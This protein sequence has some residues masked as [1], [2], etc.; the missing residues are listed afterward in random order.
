MDLNILWFILIAVL[1][2]G[3]F[4]LE[5]FDYGVGILLPFLGKTDNERRV[6][7]NSIGPVWDGNE[8]WLI[9]SGGAIF[10][11]FPN[12]YATLFSGFY[13]ALF[14]M[15]AALIVRGVAFEFRSSD[16][17][18]AWR[19]LWDG[20]L[21]A[22][23]LV[24]AL[25]WGVA[26]TNLLQGVPIDGNMQ[27][28]GGFFDLLS[29]YTL[30]GGLVFVFL[31]VFHG[32]LYLGLKTEGEMATRAERAARFA[33]GLGLVFLLVLALLTY[34][35]TDLFNKAGAAIVL[36][37]AAVAFVGAYLF[38]RRRQIGWGFLF[39]GLTI[40]FLTVAVFWGLFPRVM[41]SSLNPAWN[42]TIY[43]ASSSPY[44]LK[45]MTI[46]ALTLVPFVLAYQAWTYWVFRERVSVKKLHY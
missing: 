9:T 31:F 42:L 19:K 23:S 45:I 28:V 7:I 32:A 2:I 29:P 16:R 6:L 5:G 12:W 20:L 4:F 11:A 46:V 40:L 36:V 18:P 34:T 41:V 22:G 13:L 3:F 10:A 33:G 17:S 30:V 14:V 27:Y 24:S 25:L 35:Q 39:S 15:L 44:T 26:V 38:A 8:V 43:N 21:F 37:L 1:F